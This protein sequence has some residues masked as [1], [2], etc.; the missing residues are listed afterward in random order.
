MYF[1][2]RRLSFCPVRGGQFAPKPAVLKDLLNASADMKEKYDKPT[3]R[4]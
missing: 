3:M 2:A 4:P 1:M